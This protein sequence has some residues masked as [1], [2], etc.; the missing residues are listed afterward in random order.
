MAPPPIQR[1]PEN[2]ASHP[3]PKFLRLAECIKLLISAQ[4]RL[5]CNIFRVGGITED[6]VSYLKNA[7]LVLSDPLA[8]SLEIMRFGSGNQRTH[9]RPCHVN[10]ALSVLTP[11][12]VRSFGNITRLFAAGGDQFK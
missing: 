6:A 3:L 8:K 11:Q 5:L 9:A 12:P 10:S 1:Q 2:D 4:K 7:P